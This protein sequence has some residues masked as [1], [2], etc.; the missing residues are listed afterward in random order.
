MKKTALAVCGLF[1]L[2]GC[3]TRLVDFTILSSK[4]VDL[5][6]AATFVR[7]EGRVSGCDMAQIIVIVP[8]RTPDAGAALDRALA[9]VPGAV[10]LVDGVLTHKWFYVPY[11]Y[12]ESAYIVEGTALIDP[13]GLPAATAGR[14]GTL[15]RLYVV[16]RMD[17]NGEVRDSRVVSEKEYEHIRS[18]FFPPREG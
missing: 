17:G 3:S 10:A 16:T 4:K 15:D 12:G 1:M 6:R 5:A 7:D 8:T 14:E 11:I 2:S 9:S 13:A 18:G